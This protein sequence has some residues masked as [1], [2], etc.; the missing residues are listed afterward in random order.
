M[1]YRSNEFAMT[2]ANIRAVAKR[3]ENEGRFEGDEILF[4]ELLRRW[5]R[6]TG[7]AQ[8]ISTQRRYDFLLERHILPALGGLPTGQVTERVLEHFVEEKL[9]CGGLTGGEALSP[10]YVRSMITV[11]NAALQ[12]GR[13]RGLPVEGRGVVRKPPVLRR[14]TEVLSVAEQLRLEQYLLDT[15]SFTGLGLLLSLNTGLRIGE[16]CALAWEAVD[17]ENHTLSVVGTVSR[18]SGA[19][20]GAL[21]IRPP[22]TASSLRVIPIPS[23]LYGVLSDRRAAAS[24]AYVLSNGATFLSPRTYEYRF[25]RILERCGLRSVHYHV[26]RHTFA[27]RCVELGMDI[28]TLSELLG[29]SSTTITL[30][31]YVHSSLERKRTQIELLSRLMG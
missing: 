5:R 11:I 1:M 8:R 21:A 10:T 12:Y 26:L 30:N 20:G 24:G 16:V 13:E 25:H 17:L 6:D 22:K 18:E 27:T 14:E 4:S 7:T 28:K 29:H 19:Q 9:R 31:T 23:K 3:D 15:L 2:G